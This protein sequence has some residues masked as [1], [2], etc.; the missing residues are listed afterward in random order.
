MIDFKRICHNKLLRSKISKVSEAS[1]NAFCPVRME[2]E[3][4]KIIGI[5]IICSCVLYKFPERLIRSFILVIRRR[6]SYDIC[7]EQSR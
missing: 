6:N 5:K 3:V 2:L 7:V 4:D 1:E